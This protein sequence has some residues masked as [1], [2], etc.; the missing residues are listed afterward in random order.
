M[1]TDF[2]YGWTSA[3]RTWA[4]AHYDFA[5]SGSGADWKQANAAVTHIPYTLL[6][7][8]VI[9]G[10]GSDGLR[11]GYYADMLT[12]YAAHPQYKLENAFL[13]VPGAPRDSAHRLVKVL[14]DT[15]RWF[16]NADDPGAVAYTVDRYQRIVQGEDG[17][18]VDES[19][20]YPILTF[21]KQG[22]EYTSPAPYVALVAAVKRGIGSKMIMLNTSLYVTDFDYSIATAAGAVHL[23]QT[24]VPIASEANRRWDWIERLLNA[25]VFV[26]FVSTYSTGEEV[27]MNGRIP[28]GNAGSTAGR[29]KMWELASYYMVVGT[30]PDHL[31]LQLENTWES[32]YSSRWL[33]AQEANIGHP[34]D[35]R[36]ILTRGT[37]PVGQTYSIYQRD[38]D[39]ALVLV[40]P[41]EGWGT[42]SYLDQTAVTVPLPAGE[43]WLPLNPDGTL[44]APVTSVRLRNV[45]AAILIKKSRL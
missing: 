31:A 42:Q 1:M 11:N 8:S 44:G 14:W 16:M 27:K 40:R 3:E 29:L 22:A 30:N 37:D 13:H 21:A 23:E 2:Y 20:S 18:F 9:P 34:T 15:K 5:M 38:F 19:A 7:S 6:W 36:K 10:Q 24:N 33:K 41:Q 39:R 45:E 26:D 35:T 43:S 4:G 28:G 17:V 12:W 25:G 32:P